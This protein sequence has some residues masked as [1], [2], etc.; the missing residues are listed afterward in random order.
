NFHISDKTTT[1]LYVFVSVSSESKDQIKLT[2]PRAVSSALGASV[3]INCKTSHDV[4]V[5]S[6]YPCLHWYQ[7]KDRETPK[8]GS[9][10]GTDFTLTISRVQ[11][12]DAGVYYCQQSNSWPFTQ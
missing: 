11:T 1:L 9:Y 5:Y 12:E 10:S 2:Q 4:H 8:L 6:S 7:Q 3:T